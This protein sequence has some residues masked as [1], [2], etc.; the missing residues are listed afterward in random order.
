M[1]DH[2][3]TTVNK[4]RWLLRFHLMEPPQG[5]TPGAD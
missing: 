5:I 1:L 4:P 3:R 2:L